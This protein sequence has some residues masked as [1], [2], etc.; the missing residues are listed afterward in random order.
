MSQLKD[1]A[2]NY[3]KTFEKFEKHEAKGED[4][5]EEVLSDCCLRMVVNQICV[6]CKSPCAVDGNE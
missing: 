4:K 5:I 2:K 1:T 6:G 3:S